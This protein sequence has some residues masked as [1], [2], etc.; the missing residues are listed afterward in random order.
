[1]HD[2]AMSGS[3][4]EQAL[5]DGKLAAGAATMTGMVKKSEKLGHVAFTR[6]GCDT[7]VDM[8]VEMIESAEHIGHQTCKDHTHPLVRVTLKTSDNPKEQ[9]LIA[10][11]AQQ[12]PS[13]LIA[14]EGAEV[15][16]TL[17]IWSRDGADPVGFARARMRIRSI[18]GVPGRNAPSA[19][20]QATDTEA[21]AT[22]TEAQATDTEEH[23]E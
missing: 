20:A 3:Q 9:I 8:P 6:A 23:P 4:L 1:M 5:M 13:L 21:Q 10:L 15:V 19:E 12:P 18:F 17:M 11:L 7:W 22:D 2:K 14:T 16:G